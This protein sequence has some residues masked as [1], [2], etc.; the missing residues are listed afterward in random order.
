[1]E[2]PLVMVVL[3]W[4]VWGT[5]VGAGVA[6]RCRPVVMAATGGR[7]APPRNWKSRWWGCVL[8]GGETEGACVWSRAGGRAA[9]QSGC[10][11][12]VP[13]AETLVKQCL[14]GSAALPRR[15]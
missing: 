1:M 5:G 14:E 10:D 7:A 4:P 9:L 12:V 8:A 3:V 13:G 15:Y 11:C 6:E 2:R